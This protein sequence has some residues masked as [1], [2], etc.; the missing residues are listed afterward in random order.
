MTVHRNVLDPGAASDIDVTVPSPARIYD[1]YLGGKDNFAA[2]REA[3]EAAL[4]VVPHGRR[5]ARANRKFLVRAVKC[6]AR[7]G[8]EQFIDLGTGI[9]TSPNVHEAARS[10]TPGARVA[11]VDSDP[12]VVVH[13]TA[14]LANSGEGIISIRGDI[15]YPLNIIRNN[16]LSELIDFGRPVGLLFVAVLHFVTDMDNPHDAV[17]AFRDR[18]PPGSY[19]AVSHIAS[20]GTAP[21]VISAIENVYARSSAPAVFRTR[22]DIGAF[23]GGFH[24]VKPGI[25]EVSDWRANNRRPATPPALRFLGGV[26]CKP[27]GIRE[28][29]K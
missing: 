22:D 25:V 29:V 15:R 23:F 18:V 12:I 19:L 10:V 6:M 3:A 1:Y 26:G 13:N 14:L 16:A 27:V 4:A 7:N 24:L 9:P 21:E 11:Y 5:V 28:T 2:D 8:I 20:D 17:A